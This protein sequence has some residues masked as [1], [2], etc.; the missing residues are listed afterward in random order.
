MK[1][2]ALNSPL[3]NLNIEYSIINVV[4]NQKRIS[5]IYVIKSLVLNDFLSILKIS[6]KIDIKNPFNIKTKNKYA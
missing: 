3:L 4:I 2:K 6:N 5:S 1:I